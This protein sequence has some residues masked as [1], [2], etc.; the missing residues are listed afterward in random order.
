[1]NEEQELIR[2]VAN[3]ASIFN[4]EASYNKICKAIEQNPEA[5]AAYLELRSAIASGKFIKNLKE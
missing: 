1:M 4:T 2:L 3:K 5:K